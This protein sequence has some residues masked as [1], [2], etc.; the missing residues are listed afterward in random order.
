MPCGIK[1]TSLTQQQNDNAERRKCRNRAEIEGCLSTSQ[2]P[3][4]ADALQ[5]HRNRWE[6]LHSPLHAAAYALNP[7]NLHVVKDLDHHCHAGLLEVIKRMSIRD[8]DYAT[9]VERHARWIHIDVGDDW[10]AA[11]LMFGASR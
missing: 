10:R 1:E 6:Y 2:V 9:R 11:I 8:V 3:W 4:A 5:L 7:V